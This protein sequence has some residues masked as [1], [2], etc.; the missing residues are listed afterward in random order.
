MAN[1]LTDLIPDLYAALDVVSREL[2]GMIPA[3]TM[4]ARVDRAAEGQS[5]IIPVVPTNASVSITP[6]MGVPS[7]A[8]QTIG[9]TS[10][11]INKAKAVPFSWEGNE[12]V[13]LNSGV[14]YGNIRVN[15]IAQAMRTLVN[16]VETDLC[17][18][19]VT[20]SRAFGTAGTT[21]FGFCLLFESSPSSGGSS[22]IIGSLISTSKRKRG[23][24]RNLLA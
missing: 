21:P 8:D 19:H 2:V 13:G 18:L 17:N 12:Q 4:D 9:N 6:A 3:V 22:G 7:A 23:E 16:E 20:T 1:T 24:P 14:G 15:Q 11:V 5:V 10:V